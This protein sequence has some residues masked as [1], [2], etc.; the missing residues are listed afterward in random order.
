MARTLCR[1]VKSCQSIGSLLLMKT[2]L[3]PSASVLLRTVC[4]RR[5]VCMSACRMTCSEESAW[6]PWRGLCEW[7]SAMRASWCLVNLCSCPSRSFPNGV[8]ASYLTAENLGFDILY[9]II[10]SSI[11]IGNTCDWH[12]YMLIVEAVVCSGVEMH[13]NIAVLDV[14]SNYTHKE[15]KSLK[16]EDYH[17][18]AC[19][20]DAA[21][22]FF[23]QGP[24]L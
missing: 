20:A 6:N 1:I 9:C 10:K 19:V 22:T 12:N 5:M 14:L 13:C 24:G 3:H 8:I 17:G 11:Y 2:R 7:V 23:L 4:V 16:T 21:I 18:F 15:S